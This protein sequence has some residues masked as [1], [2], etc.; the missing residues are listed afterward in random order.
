MT[1]FQGLL[2]FKAIRT[3][4]DAIRTGATSQSEDFFQI[5]PLEVTIDPEPLD[6][7]RE[8]VMAQ[9]EVSLDELIRATF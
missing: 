3:A 9:L 5:R 6:Q 1:R 8:R 2:S 4:Y 7:L